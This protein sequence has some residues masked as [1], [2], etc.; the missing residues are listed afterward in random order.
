MYHLGNQTLKVPMKLFATNRVNLLKRLRNNPDLPKSSIVLLLGGESQN[1]HCTDHELLFRQE[2]YFHWCFGVTEPDFLGAI[3]VDTGRTI[4][5][6]PLLPASYGIIMGKVQPESY[7]KERYQVDEV[8][9]GNKLVDV[10]KAASPSA[11]LLLHGL[12]TDSGNYSKP[13]HF[14]EIEQFNLDKAI[15]HPCISECRVYKSD[16]EIEVMRYTNKISSE[17][18]KE[19]M[20]SIKPGMMEYELESIFQ[21][22]CYRLGGMRFM[23]YTCICASGENN[24]ILHYGHAGAPNNKQV[25]DEELTLFDMGG[26][27]YCYASDITCSYPSNGVFNK[28]QKLIYETVLKANQSVQAA[29]KP[30][31]SWTDMHLLADRTI[32]EELKKEGL[33]VGDINEMMEHR[34]GAVFMPHGL[35][36]FIGCD[37]HDV[38]GYN[39]GERS[40]KPGLKSLRFARPVEERMVVTVEPGCYMIDYLL[41][42]AL[43]DPI[44]SKFLVKEE[45]AKYRGIGGVRIEDDVLITATGIDLLTKVPR[46]VEEIETFMKENNV[47]VK[48]K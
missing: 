6:P 47:H 3:E 33:L 10:L 34:I 37:T 43:A 46:T 27:Y 44:K 23:S 30:G 42:E 2:S 24:A 45:L 13:A 11:L 5:F 48:S 40:D 16:Y 12:N 41:D 36:H 19:V 28:K 1:R 26:E 29:L 18:H 7:F 15:L 8:H 14:P 17:A 25:Q 21:D 31:V 9:F 35:G 39:I 20:K 32:L 22:H 38:G 4:L